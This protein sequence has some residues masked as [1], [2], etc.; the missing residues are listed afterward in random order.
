MA[1]LPKT[2][3]GPQFSTFVCFPVAVLLLYGVTSMFPKDIVV[4]DY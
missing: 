3:I 2:P 4:L 1:F